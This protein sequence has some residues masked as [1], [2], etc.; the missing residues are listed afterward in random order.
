MELIILLGILVVVGSW[1]YFGNESRRAAANQ[2]ARKTLG[3][4]DDT[5]KKSWGRLD[6]VTKKA[7][8]EAA[9]V[10]STISQSSQQVLEKVHLIKK[11]DDFEPFKKWL[12]DENG[13]KRLDAINL[14]ESMDS[15]NQWFND[16]SNVENQRLF[17]E[18][19]AQFS[20]DNRIKLQWIINDGFFAQQDEIKQAMQGVLLLQSI[21]WHKL[22]TI[23][24]ELEVLQSYEIWKS[25]PFKGKNLEIS[26]KMFAKMIDE[27]MV[28]ASPELLL[29]PEKKRREYVVQSVVEYGEKDLKSFLKM[30]KE[31]LK[32]S[33]FTIQDEEETASVLEGEVIESRPAQKRANRRSAE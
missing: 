23:Q 30:F 7:I 15:L 20:K 13:A 27:R 33:K 12:L 16:E 17:F 21:V 24:P 28:T 6:G 1:V 9:K 29:A 25:D 11:S 5:A 18:K 14:R 8:N 2:T 32:E 31:V 26:Q 22:N 4:V 10:T 3:L 19:I